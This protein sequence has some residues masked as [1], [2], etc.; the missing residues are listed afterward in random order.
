L[1]TPWCGAPLVAT[2]SEGRQLLVGVLKDETTEGVLD[3]AS[4]RFADVE[5]ARAW[6]LAA[7]GTQSLPS[8]NTTYT[9]MYIY[10]YIHIHIYI[11][12]YICICICLDVAE[13]LEWDLGVHVMCTRRSEAF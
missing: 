4:V 5:K 2:T 11:H 6:I 8:A 1:A 10:I 7:S 12:V 13:A 3:T 9:Y